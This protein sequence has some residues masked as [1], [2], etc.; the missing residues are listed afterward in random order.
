MSIFLEIGIIFFVAT[1]VSLVLKFI[2][3]PL[4][5]GYIFTGVLVGPYV[6]NILK[7]TELVDLFSKIGI[8]ILLFIVGL[9]LNPTVIKENGKVSFLTGI[10]QII[11]TS[12]FGFIITFFL[13]Y[14]T[15][16]SIY[17]AIALTFSSTIIIMKLLSDRGD[18][19]KLY[20]R[21][22]IGFL[23][24]QD[25]VATLLLVLI[26]VLG[27]LYTSQT[28]NALETIN[29][30]LVKSVGV[31]LLTYLATRLVIKR[32]I[33]FIA[34]S[35]ELLFIFSISW[36]LVVASLFFYAGLSIEIGALVAGVM[37]SSTNYA[38]EIT[39]KLKPLRD[40]FIVLFFILLG[41]H[42]AIN[43]L[44]NVLVPSIVLS[45]FVLIGNPLIVFYIMNYLGYKNKIGFMCGLAVAQISEFSLILMALGASLGHVSKDSISLVTLVGI[46]TISGSTYMV[47]YADKLLSIVSPL[48]NKIQIF[49]NR[50]NKI[51]VKR[52]N[53]EQE[54]IIFGY[55]NVGSEF[56]NSA[57]EINKKFIVVDYDPQTAKKMGTHTDSFIFGDAEDIEFLNEIKFQ[58]AEYL[59][60]TIPNPYVNLNLLKYYRKKNKDGIAILVSHNKEETERMYLAGAT[61]V[62]MPHFLGAHHAA[63]ILIK[64]E[65]NHDIFEHER[66]TQ[67]NQLSKSL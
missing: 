14:D 19:G 7:S 17:V 37:L 4:V 57:L 27:A 28:S 21:I 9:S 53:S 2:K 20:G 11:F 32:I 25:I 55:G 41:S 13:G 66:N 45:I 29:V 24:V 49:K 18:L 3:Q 44:Q 64:G 60:S 39:S 50:V 51:R 40:F 16:T 67:L 56:V 47:I 31:F 52:N 46:I 43:D 33:N 8:A 1:L 12:I 58:K 23:L 42:L 36:G 65:V 5:V 48:L 35:G 22:S 15:L 62:I 61:Y 30:L 63:K 59:I 10:G 26:P 34:E 6:F 54:M 38:F